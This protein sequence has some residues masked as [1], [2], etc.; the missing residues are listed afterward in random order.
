VDL[1]RELGNRPLVYAAICHLLAGA[2]TGSLFKVRTLLI[3][4][5]LVLAESAILIFVQGSIAWEWTLINLVAVEFGYLAG[6]LSRHILE[7]VGYSLPDVGAP[8]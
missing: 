8:P 2:V 3:L 6:I 7:L 4:L 5:S 1:I